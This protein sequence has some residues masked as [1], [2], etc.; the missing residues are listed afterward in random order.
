VFAIIL[1]QAVIAKGGF[2]SGARHKSGDPTESPKKSNL[3]VPGTHTSW[4]FSEERV[5]THRLAPQETEP[6]ISAVREIN[7]FKISGKKPGTADFGG[8]APQRLPTLAFDFAVKADSASQAGPD[9]ANRRQ[10]GFGSD[11][12]RRRAHGL[13]LEAWLKK[14]AG[15]DLPSAAPCSPQEAAARILQLQSA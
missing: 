15:E 5:F 9:L 2:W 7:A 12:R 4:Q 1:P 11:S 6:P 8:L 3:S 10:T 13:T 14:L